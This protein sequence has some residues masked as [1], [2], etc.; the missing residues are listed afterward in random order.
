MTTVV[1]AGPPWTARSAHDCPSMSAHGPARS[2]PLPLRSRHLRLY[3]LLTI[4]SGLPPLHWSG[5]RRPPLRARW[6]PAAASSPPPPAPSCQLQPQRGPSPGPA[7]DPQGPRPGRAALPQRRRSF[8]IQ[9]VPTGRRCPRAARGRGVGAAR[10]VAGSG[11][12]PDS[13]TREVEPRTTADRERAGDPCWAAPGTASPSFG[14]N[15][16]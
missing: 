3:T 16:S 4:G 2:G 15:S 7:E 6:D 9:R 14:M 12:Q 1:S 11:S 10:D 8:V 13:L 5:R